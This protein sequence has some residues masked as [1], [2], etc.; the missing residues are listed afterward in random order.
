MAYSGAKGLL[1]CEKNLKSKIS[2]HTPF[3]LF[4]TSRASL[5]GLSDLPEGGPLHQANMHHTRFLLTQFALIKFCITKYCH[6]FAR[7]NL[8]K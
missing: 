3:K 2:C 7:S 1:I 4:R 8:D 6:L 5:P